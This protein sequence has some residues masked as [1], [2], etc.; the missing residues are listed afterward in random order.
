MRAVAA[1]TVEIASRGWY[2]TGE[3]NRVDLGDLVA[4]AVAGTRLYKPGDPVPAAVPPGT[5]LVV[6]VVN[7]TT[8]VAARVLGGNVACLVF[9]SARHPG[10]GFLNGLGRRRRAWPGR[11]PCM[12]ARTPR[13]GSTTSTASTRTRVTATG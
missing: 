2:L 1:E 13:R 12:R 10:G 3:G 9:A 8:L 11:R 5:D 4:A 6:T 7:Q